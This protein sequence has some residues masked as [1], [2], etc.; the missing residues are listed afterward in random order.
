MNVIGD[1]LV[2]VAIVGVMLVGGIWLGMLIAPRL[3][4]LTD[5]DEEG[6]GDDD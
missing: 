4:R 1:L 2:F 3:G 5:D 6:S